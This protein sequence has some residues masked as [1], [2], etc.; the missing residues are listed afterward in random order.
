MSW[1]ASTRSPCSTWSTCPSWLHFRRIHSYYCTT[2]VPP[3]AGRNSSLQVANYPPQ[4]FCDAKPDIE[5][6]SCTDNYSSRKEDEPASKSLDVDSPLSPK[7]YRRLRRASAAPTASQYSG[8]ISSRI[9][10]Q[11]SQQDKSGAK[12]RSRHSQASNYLTKQKS[13]NLPRSRNKVTGHERR[14]KNTSSRRKQ[15]VVGLDFQMK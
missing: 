11:A 15:I 1:P 8:K 13:T 14:Q 2:Q 5:A 10:L 9:Q 12:I 3:E 6:H 7:C 4:P